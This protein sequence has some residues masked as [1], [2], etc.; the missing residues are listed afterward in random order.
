VSTII[1][2]VDSKELD[3]LFASNVQAI[4]LSMDVTLAQLSDASRI[5]FPRLEGIET[6]GLATRDERR[7]ITGALARLSRAR[8]ITCQGP[9]PEQ[10]FAPGPRVY[11]PPQASAPRRQS[12]RRDQDRFAMTDCNIL[13][14]CDP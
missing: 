2:T 8:E 5:P 9:P 6:G 13:R 11:H 7:D 1:I 14:S 3:W 12:H 4:R 10:L